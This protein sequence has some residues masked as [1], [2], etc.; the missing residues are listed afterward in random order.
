MLFFD[1]CVPYGHAISYVDKKYDKHLKNRIPPPPRPLTNTNPSSIPTSTTQSD[2]SSL[3]L[4]SNNGRSHPVCLKQPICIAHNSP[5]HSIYY[6]QHNKLLHHHHH[7]QSVLLLV[8]FVSPT[9]LPFFR[10]AHSLQLIEIGQY[11][12]NVKI[13]FPRAFS[14]Y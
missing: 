3:L 10:A 11:N 4:Q 13:V 14:C 7:H 8:S 12:I 1:G 6:Q 5:C 9:Q 2:G